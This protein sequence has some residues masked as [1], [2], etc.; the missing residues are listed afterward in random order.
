M[1]RGRFR[2]QL[3]SATRAGSDPA[4][5]LY[6]CTQAGAPAWAK[7]MCMVLPDQPC[8]VHTVL[9]AGSQWAGSA[10]LPALQTLNSERE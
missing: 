2:R 8:H 3:F 9:H 1:L 10:D 6:E 4:C 5:G 7:C